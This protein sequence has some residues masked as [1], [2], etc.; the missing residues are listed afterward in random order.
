MPCSEQR[1]LTRREFAHGA[2]LAGGAVGLLRPMQAAAPATV[3]PAGSDW[4]MYRRDPA[5]TATSPLR[6]GLGETPHVVWSLELGGPKLTAETVLVRD[7][8]GSGS[9]DFLTISADTL[10]CRDARGLVRW[11]LENMLNVSIQQILDFAGDGS[12]GILLTTSRAG[13]VD[14]FMIDGRTGKATHLWLDQNNFGGHTRVG[15]LLPD[16]NGLQIASTS[17]GQTPPAPQ[18]GHVRLVSFDKGLDAPTFHINQRVNGVFYSPL[19]LVTDMDGDGHPE[20]AVLSHEQLWVFDTKQGSQKLYA[21]YGPAIRTYMAT[22]QTVRLRPEDSR[23]SLVMINPSLPGLKAVAQDGATF[24]RELW[25]VVIGG[26]EDQYQKRVTVVPAGPS[27]VYD[28]DGDGHPLVFTLIKNEHA[29]SMTKLVVFDARNGTRLAEL[30]EAQVLSADDL[31]GDGKVEFLLQ[32]GRD[33]VIC[34]WESNQLRTL[35]QSA[36]VLPVLHSSPTEGDPQLTS[37]SS[38]ISRGNVRVWRVRDGSS[39]FLL[40]FPEGVFACRL[41]HD[42]LTRGDA[43]AQH[44]AFGTNP[45]A[46]PGQPRV[47]WDG[48]KLVTLVDGQEVF[49]YLPPAPTT[50]LAPPPIV[51]DLAGQ[52][53]ILVRD[54]SSNYLLCSARGELERVWAE[55]AHGVAE[56]LV[57]P[58]GLAPVVSDVDDD[59]E[60]E[61]LLTVTE[62]GGQP[63]CLLLDQNGKEKRR[64]G[65]LPGMKNLN[66]GPTGRL[67]PG[68]GR[69]ILLRMSGENAQGER[70]FLVVAYDGKTGEQ[71]WV[72]DHYGNY[73]QNPVVFVAHFPGA[74]W[75]YN[76]DGA[77]DWLVCSENFYGIVDVRANKDLVGPVVLSDALAGHWTAYTFPSLASLRDGDPPWVVHHSAYAMG[78]VTNLEGQ[79]VWHYGMTRDSASKW[80]QCADLDGDGQRELLHVQP[81]GVLRCFSLATHARCPTCATESALAAQTDSPERWRFDMQRPVGRML[82]ADLDGDGRMELL[83]GCEDGKL[84]AL[85]ERN[86]TPVLLWSVPLGR[87]VGEPILTDLDGDGLPEILVTA[88]DG[89]LYCLKGN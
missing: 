12:R 52:R 43:I 2:L 34:R 36:D 17:S 21:A 23:A 39:E 61:V 89:K 74:V 65:L 48:V 30:P 31:D 13:R 75:D 86:G 83:F 80:A 6:G 58:A 8:T 29:D 42:Q 26:V 22:V 78:L 16:R 46:V 14:Q 63:V 45:A 4:P 79:P 62:A 33:L 27:L 37:G 64:W 50:Y 84:Y 73:G 57:D 77:D 28:P 60:P 40:R 41:A 9:E 68:R 10:T 87:R 15:K 59:G 24:A 66:P 1:P 19:I 81:D 88:E 55:R 69:W 18:G 56:L 53:R 11:R 85:A 71:L 82:A 32:C 5:L 25:R 44:E 70:T 76:R 72:R 35:W 47:V 67:G 20:L 54:A 3:Y 51:A 38:P 49:R 7:V